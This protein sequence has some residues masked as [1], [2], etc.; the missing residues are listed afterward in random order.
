VAP[1]FGNEPFE[2]P[3]IVHHLLDVLLADVSLG[4]IVQD[5]P[6]VA[7]VPDNGPITPFVHM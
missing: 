2:T 6:P 5:V 1:A 4:M 3:G 7:D